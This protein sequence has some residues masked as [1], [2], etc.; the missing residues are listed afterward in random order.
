MSHPLTT[1]RESRS[2]RRLG[3]HPIFAVA[4]EMAGDCA[5]SHRRCD[6][7]RNDAISEAWFVASSASLFRPCR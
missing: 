5:I 3:G 6:S 7:Y 2:Y 1:A 4:P